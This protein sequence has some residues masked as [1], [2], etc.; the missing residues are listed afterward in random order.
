MRSQE[1]RLIVNR[2]ANVRFI[3]IRGDEH[4]KEQIDEVRNDLTELIPD[5]DATLKLVNNPKYYVHA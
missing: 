3:Q 4:V 5:N 1:S 2:F